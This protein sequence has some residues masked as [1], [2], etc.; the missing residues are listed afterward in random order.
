[1]VT[2]RIELEVL[3]SICLSAAHH[4]SH[5]P[6]RTLVI[7]VGSTLSTIQCKGPNQWLTQVQLLNGRIE[8]SI[9]KPSLDIK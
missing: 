2:E 4:L 6:S 7:L 1:M 9:I 3:L 5:L 8:V